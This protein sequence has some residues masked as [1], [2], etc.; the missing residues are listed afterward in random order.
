[1]GAPAVSWDIEWAVDE[2]FFSSQIIE[3]T[4]M[5]RSSF[6]PCLPCA[7]FVWPDPR[8]P[9]KPLGTVHMSSFVMRLDVHLILQV[10][11]MLC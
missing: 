5:L 1:M 8:P 6:T 7:V 2:M 11:P 4:A 3:G 10:L 9:S